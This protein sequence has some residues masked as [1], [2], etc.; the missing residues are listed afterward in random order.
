MGRLI[1]PKNL[2][3]RGRLITLPRYGS[4]RMRMEKPVKKLSPLVVKDLEQKNRARV[5]V[6][7]PPLRV[8][9]RICMVCRRPFESVGSYT[10]GCSPRPQE[11][12]NHL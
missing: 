9:I 7:L 12:N 6:S 10:C 5:L 4:T 11:I 8:K 3:E 2:Q 1:S